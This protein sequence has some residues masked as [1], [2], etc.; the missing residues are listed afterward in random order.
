MASVPISAMLREQSRAAFAWL[1]GPAGRPVVAACLLG[2]A[3]LAVFTLY[4][5]AALGLPIAR[6]EPARFDLYH[7]GRTAFALF[8]AA[9]AVSALVRARARPS[10]LDVESCSVPSQVAAIL[11]L[12]A[13]AGA[14]LL[15]VADPAAF[16]AQAQEDRPLEW[17]SAGLLLAAAGLFAFNAARGLRAGSGR[18]WL[19]LLAGGGLAALLLV[20][21][22]EEISWGQRLFGFATPDTLAQMNWQGEFNFHN[23][24]TDLSELIYYAG[25]SLFLGLLPLLRDLVPPVAAAHPLFAFVP[26]RGVALVAAPAAAFN[27][28]HWNLLPVQLGTMLALF[29]LLAFAGAATRRG[30]RAERALFLFAAAAIVAGQ[31]LFLVYGPAMT[32]LPDATEYK[33]FFIA[34]GF[35]WYALTARRQRFSGAAAV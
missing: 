10:A 33:E 6:E 25:A 22:M 5:T 23:I 20:M 16:H 31:M 17:A 7:A 15:F 34:L 3:G 18:S 27:Y 24:Q 32:E 8:A 35:A 29:A 28:G 11:V 21:A 30:D 14:T 26:R 4:E 2:L 13:A 19:A 1:A 12:A 9:L